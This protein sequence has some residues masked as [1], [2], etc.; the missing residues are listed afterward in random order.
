MLYNDAEQ[1]SYPNVILKQQK[2]RN[3]QYMFRTVNLPAIPYHSKLLS[4]HS[5]NTS[6]FCLEIC[7]WMKATAHMLR[8]THILNNM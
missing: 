1:V 5:N 2:W 3:E 7:T 8:K 4:C 6:T